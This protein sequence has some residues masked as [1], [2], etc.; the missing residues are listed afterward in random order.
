MGS[1]SRRGASVVSAS[2][3]LRQRI[4][5]STSTCW[6]SMACMPRIKKA[7]HPLPSGASTLG[8]RSGPG[9]R[10]YSPPCRQ[11]PGTPIIGEDVVTIS[12]N[13]ARNSQFSCL[14]RRAE[15]VR[16]Q[17]HVGSPTIR[18]SSRESYVVFR[19]SRFLISRKHTLTVLFAWATPVWSLR[20][21][22]PAAAN[23]GFS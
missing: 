23:A 10:L 13:R 5:P 16:T 22:W 2:L 15:R 4:Y 19:E 1:G 18:V 21:G 12:R 17:F 11:A 3:N 20:S 6:R 14:P 9:G 7:S 8:C